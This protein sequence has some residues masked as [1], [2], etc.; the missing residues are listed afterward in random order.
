MLILTR[1]F[2]VLM[3]IRVCVKCFNIDVRIYS[4]RAFSSSFG[5]FVCLFVCLFVSCW[6]FVMLILINAFIVLVLFDCQVDVDVDNVQRREVFT[7]YS[8]I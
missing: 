5:L 4:T 1:A 3:F 8:A 2:I 7:G 6:L